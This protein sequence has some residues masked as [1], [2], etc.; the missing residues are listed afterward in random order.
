L[1][2]L[3]VRINMKVEFYGADWCGDC[4]RSKSLL[5]RLQVEFEYHDV[6]SSPE[7]ARRAKE[8]SGKTNIPVIRFED[9]VFLVEPSDALL[10]EE[11]KKR[12]IVSR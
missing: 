4:R 6:S 11:L 2:R 8:I 5:N 1:I 7:D 3:K 10:L 9:G 12:S